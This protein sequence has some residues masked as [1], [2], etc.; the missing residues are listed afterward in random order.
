MTKEISDILKKADDEKVKNERRLSALDWFRNRVQ[1]LNKPIRP[2]DLLSDKERLQD[3]F[4]YGKMYNFR[5]DPKTKLTLPYYDLFPLCIPIKPVPGGFIGLNL[6][7]L[8]PKQR[9]FLLS[10]ISELEKRD[11][12]GELKYKMTYNLLNSSAKYKAFKPCVKRYLYSYIKSKFV[13][14]N[15]KEWNVA[16]FLP[17]EMFV[18][19]KKTFVWE[20]SSQK[21]KR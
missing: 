13:K 2:V 10:K 20:E 16:I 15:E 17:T 1:N 18:K 21:I 11:V 7:Y 3:R 14:I 19:K 4:E 9:A 6:H 12:T 8:Y 5:Y